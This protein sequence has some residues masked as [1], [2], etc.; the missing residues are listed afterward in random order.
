MIYVRECFTYALFYIPPLSDN[1]NEIFLWGVSPPHSQSMN[2]RDSSYSLT[3]RKHKQ[4]R[5]T[6]NTQ[7][8]LLQ[9][10]GEMQLFNSGYR[11]E[12]MLTLSYDDL[13][14]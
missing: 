11:T 1:S 14:H 6:N 8:L 3:S 5:L 10:W 2:L 4:P 12:I 7:E 13:L 9:S